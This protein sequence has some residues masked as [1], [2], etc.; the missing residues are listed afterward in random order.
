MTTIPA[1]LLH[2]SLPSSVSRILLRF[3]GI[4]S[5]TCVQGIV[6]LQDVQELMLTG[7]KAGSI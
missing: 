5:R 7:R 4:T 2:C 3:G 6:S 1:V